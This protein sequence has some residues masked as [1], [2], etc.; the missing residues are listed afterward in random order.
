MTEFQ[1]VAPLLW[2]G[3]APLLWQ[4]VGGSR[5][6][7]EVPRASPGI[8]HPGRC[9]QCPAVAPPQTLLHVGGI[10]NRTKSPGVLRCFLTTHSCPLIS[11]VTTTTHSC[12]LSPAQAT[13]TRGFLF[14][15]PPASPWSGLSLHSHAHSSQPLPS[16]AGVQALPGG[17]A[18]LCRAPQAT[19]VAQPK[20]KPPS[21]QKTR[22]PHPSLGF[23]EPHNGN[24]LVEPPTSSCNY[25]LCSI[26]GRWVFC[27]HTPGDRGLTTLFSWKALIAGKPVELSFCLLR[28]STR[29]SRPALRILMR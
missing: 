19:P 24:C 20:E 3:V 28:I 27:L 15:S 9:P 11:P 17:W 12:D 6:G 5:H 25:S 4:G 1:G 13:N 7:A 29:G 14:C 18:W 8:S 10:C 21:V 22:L 23:T 26:T 2:Q 16:R